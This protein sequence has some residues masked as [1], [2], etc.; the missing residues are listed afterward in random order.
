M[1]RE[2]KIAFTDSLS[3]L[4]CSIVPAHPWVYGLGQQTDTGAYLSPVNA[5]S[6]LAEKLAGMG[7]RADVIIMMVTGQTNDSFVSNLNQMID[8]FPAPA[9]TQVKRLALSAAELAKEKMQIPARYNAGLADALP[10]SVPTSRAALAAST[11]R[12]AQEEAAS[13][14]DIGA[15]KKQLDDFNQLRNGVLDEI[16]GGLAELQGKSAKAWVFTASGDLATTLLAL[17][18]GIPLQSAVYSAA[19]M[20][21][22]DNLDSIKGMI[23][24]LEPDAGA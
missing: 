24:D 4:D 17:V 1:W 13:V 7:G 15:L 12:K 11:V 22:G 19:M 2:A 23:H 16:A 10:L 18:R 14:M 3:S 9:F 21:V 8:V 20:L 5:I 6:Y